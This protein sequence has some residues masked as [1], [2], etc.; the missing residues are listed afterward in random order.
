MAALRKHTLARLPDA[1]PFA[2]RSERASDIVA[3]ETLLDA[4]FGVRPGSAVPNSKFASLAARP[5]A[6]FEFDQDSRRFKV[7]VWR[8]FRKF[9]RRDLPRGGGEFSKRHT[10]GRDGAVVARQRRRRSGA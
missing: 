10:P 7:C 9:P 5:G 3:R 2:I 4:T 1:A 8:M 6:N